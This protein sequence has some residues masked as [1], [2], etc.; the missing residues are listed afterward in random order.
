MSS[1]YD[2]PPLPPPKPNSVPPASRTSTP[3]QPSQLQLPA[4]PTESF[5]PDILHSKSLSDLQVLHSNPELLDA[6]FTHTH[7]LSCTLNSTL[8]ATLQ[9]NSDLSTHLQALE[10]ALQQTRETTECRLLETR[11]L[12]RQWREKEKEMYQSLQ[13]FSSPAL[14]NRLTNAVSEAEG[15]SEALAA[16]FLEEGGRDVGDFV[17]EYRGMRKLYHLRK[18]R[19]ERWDEGRVGGWR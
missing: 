3:L 18:E 11:N 10:A 16:S 8:A 13:P 6:L 19:K 15:L 17:R 9:K 1:P 4:P 14:Y 2:N 12:E 5:I 7:P